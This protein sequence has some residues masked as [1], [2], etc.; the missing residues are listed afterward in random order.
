MAKEALLKI[1]QAEN[2]AL[3]SIKKSRREFESEIQNAKL[4]A[5]NMLNDQIKENKRNYDEKVNI[6]LEES[7]KSKQN[8]EKWVNS[9]CLGLEEKFNLNSKKAVDAVVSQLIQSV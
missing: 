5:Q 7:K 3:E 9:K 8:F 6:Y 2:K 1:I 4:F